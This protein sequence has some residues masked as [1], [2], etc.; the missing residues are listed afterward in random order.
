MVNIL[1][2]V[3]VKRGIFQGNSLLSLFFILSMLTL[4]LILR[5]VN[6]SY[7][8]R[9]K[10]YKLNHLLFMNDLKHFSKSEEQ[11]DTLVKTIYVFSTDIGTEFEIKKCGILT[12]KKRKVVRC[13]IMKSPNS[14]VIK[15]VTL[16]KSD[17]K[18]GTE[19]LLCAA[20]EQVIRTNYIKRHSH[21]TS[22]SPLFRLCGK[23]VR[24]CNI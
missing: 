4:S 10:E 18:I 22:E 17:L 16:S 14:E 8:W 13:E 7:D 5:K 20:Q 21:K 23:K 11:M 24:V 9:K 12:M 19:A 6:G 1:G 3:D 15:E 2:E